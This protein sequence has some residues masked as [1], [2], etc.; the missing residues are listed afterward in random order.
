MRSSNG[1][2]YTVHL[3]SKE[4]CNCPSTT[5]YWHIIASKLSLGIK[6]STKKLT[7][8]LS[9]LKRNSR[10]K[11]GKKSGRKCQRPNDTDVEVTVAPDS[12]IN[13]LNKNCPVSKIKK[14]KLTKVQ[15]INADSGTT[16]NEEIDLTADFDTIQDGIVT[17][18]TPPFRGDGSCTGPMV[19][20]GG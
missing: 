12:Q 2:T 5:T 1:K 6:D 19:G 4:M 10:T 11:L 18:V 14:L 13:T 17:G 7:L 9:Q 20:V 15:N 3:Y 8:N 16:H